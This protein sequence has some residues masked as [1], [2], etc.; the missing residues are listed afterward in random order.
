MPHNAGPDTNVPQEQ[1]AVFITAP[2]GP[3]A[4]QMRRTAVPMPGDAEVLI[5]VRAAG[6]VAFRHHADQIL[7][8]EN[9][10]EPD[11]LFLH[12]AQRGARRGAGLDGHER[13]ALRG[14]ELARRGE[15]H[16]L[17]ERAQPRAH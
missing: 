16:E 2:G 13:L 5:R 6:D 7:I 8:V 9:R 1:D 12:G 4:L 14:D 17:L 10:R 3:D 15:R 11:V